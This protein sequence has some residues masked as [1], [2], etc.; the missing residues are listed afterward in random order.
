MH[1]AGRLALV[2]GAGSGIGRAI[3]LALARDGARVAALD[4]SIRKAEETHSLIAEAGGYG[5]ALECDVTNESQVANVMK[6]IGGSHGVVDI[7]VN[8][9]GIGDRRPPLD[10][11]IANWRHVIEVNL[12]GAF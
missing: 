7:L 11:Q 5:C 8:C 3:C 10:V 1:L 12:T 2:T 6:Q 4:L 9:A